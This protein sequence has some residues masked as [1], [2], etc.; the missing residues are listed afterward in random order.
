MRLQK[1][2]ET[3]LCILTSFAMA[4]DMPAADLLE[5]IGGGWKTLAFPNL[6]VPYCY[7]GIHIQ[8]LILI[9]LEQSYAV[10]PIELFPQT[11]SP[12][13]INPVTR[14]S[15]RDVTV[16]YGATEEANWRIFNDVIRTCSGVIT[17]R[18]APSMTRFQRHH[19]V[20]FDKGTILDPS[21]GAFLYSVQ[22]C[23][24]RN[25]YSGTAWRFDKIGKS[26]D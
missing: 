18:L 26:N 6:P 5:Q 12:K 10:T 14:K 15:Y 1:S 17:G 3:G 2:S 19:A 8:E 13:A 23:E 9:A 25:F 11:S 7:R 4:L 24:N 22:Q 21:S 16:F 20:A